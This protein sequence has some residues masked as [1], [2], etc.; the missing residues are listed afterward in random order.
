MATQRITLDIAYRCFEIADR[1]STGVISYGPV[2]VGSE[3][4]GSTFSASDLFFA[5]RICK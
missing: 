5:S 3:V 4:I 2:P 1:T